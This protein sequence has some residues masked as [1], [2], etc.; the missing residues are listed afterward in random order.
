MAKV[1]AN[2]LLM[3]ELDLKIK[4]DQCFIMTCIGPKNKAQRQMVVEMLKKKYFC[5][6]CAI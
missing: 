2:G 5:D 4:C 3:Q 1:V 6:A